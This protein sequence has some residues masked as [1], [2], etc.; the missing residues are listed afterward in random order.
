[1]KL[2]LLTCISFTLATVI[3]EKQFN[4]RGSS[5]TTSDRNATVKL[6]ECTFC[7]PEE[8]FRSKTVHAG[9]EWWPKEALID[10]DFST[11]YSSKG[12]PTANTV[13]WVAFWFNDGFHPVNFVDMFPRNQVPVYCFPESFDVYYSDGPQWHLVKSLD[14]YLN[15]AQCN[16]PQRVYF[17]TVFANGIQI[18]ARKLR[19]D[20]HGNYYFQLSEARAGYSAPC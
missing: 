1:M 3:A 20:D 19:P 11:V 7:G 10:N 13:E 4:I 15:P 6:S 18:L 2:K 9:S 14:N 8:Y 12:S 17:P 16:Y 5:L